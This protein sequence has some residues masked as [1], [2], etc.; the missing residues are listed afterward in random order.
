MSEIIVDT[1]QP[2]ILRITMNRPERRHAV[3]PELRAEILAAIKEG[4]AA[5][6]VRC[7]ILTGSGGYFSGGGDLGRISKLPRTEY[8]SYMEGLA[9]FVKGL[10]ACSKP[11]IAAV[12]G[13][14][15]GG[16]AGFALACDFIVM[17]R[18]AY[19]TFPFFRIGLI[20]D[21]GIL[22]HLPRRVGLAAARRVLLVQHKVEAPEAERIRLADF[23]V[24]DEDVQGEA[25][26]LAQKL[27][28]QPVQAMHLTRRMLQQDAP[29]LAEVLTQEGAAQIA[30]LQ[31]PEFAAG[32]DA[33]LKKQSEKS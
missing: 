33:F 6:S 10:S 24:A 12:E 20:P 29:S 23:I 13:C 2:E 7:I 8:P 19:F 18:S 17:G 25:V 32:V 28:G 5:P 16:G 4:E 30:C 11:V 27:A 21:A 26:K 9:R 3:T 14:A 22:Y 31:S 1:P 15:A